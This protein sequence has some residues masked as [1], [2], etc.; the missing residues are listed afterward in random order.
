MVKKAD[1]YKV[2]IN[3]KKQYSILRGDQV[4]S[5]GW[6]EVGKI[7]TKT[8][9]LNYIEEVWTDMKASDKRRILDSLG[10]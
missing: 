10:K 2:V 5:R 9:C 1:R 6:K 4:V 7:G 3:H 8:E